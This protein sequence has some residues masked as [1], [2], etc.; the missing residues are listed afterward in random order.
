[1]DEVKRFPGVYRGVVK[2]N[3]DPQ[4]QRRLKLQVQTTGSEITDWAWPIESAG[5]NVAVPEVGQ[6]VWVS[7]AGGDPEYPIWHGKFGK[8][9][10]KSKPVKINPLQDSVSLTG[11]TSYLIINTL[12]D[13]TKEV[14]L[15]ASLVAMANKLKDHE[16]RIHTLETTPDIDG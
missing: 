16:T 1:M 4:N 7:Y 10:G 15:V 9:Q 12:A 2:D 8:H 11:L 14:D 3:K 13:G 5:L 6:G